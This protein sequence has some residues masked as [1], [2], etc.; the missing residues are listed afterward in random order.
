MVKTRIKA[1]ALPIPTSEEA[2]QAMLAEIGVID[3]A[4]EAEEQRRQDAVKEIETS[5]DELVKKLREEIDTKFLA[6]K[7]YVEANQQELLPKDRRSVKWPTGVVGF[8][9]RPLSAVVARGKL[10][11]VIQQLEVLGLDDCVKVKK[12][13][14]KEAAKKRRVAIDG[15]VEHISFTTTT[16]FFAQAG[17]TSVEHTKAVPKPRVTKTGKKGA[18]A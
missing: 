11:S 8:R 13:L 18:A 4:I 5:S 6:L 9:D 15:I 2:A 14:D 7:A 10:D 17:T 12:S 3:R 1:D 16:E